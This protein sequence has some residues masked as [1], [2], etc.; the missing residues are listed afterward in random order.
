ML[1]V[2]SSEYKV[3]RLIGCFWV[4]SRRPAS[5]A[6]VADLCRRHQGFKQEGEWPVEKGGAD[7]RFGNPRPSRSTFHRFVFRKGRMSGKPDR[8]TLKCSYSRG[9]EGVG[10]AGGGGG[11]VRVGGEGGWRGGG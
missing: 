2:S 11:G 3:T 1:T 8:I 10:G 6:G 7:K 4:E 5:L 9:D